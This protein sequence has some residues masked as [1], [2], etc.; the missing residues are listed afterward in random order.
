MVLSHMAAQLKQQLLADNIDDPISK[1][2]RRY[3]LW[4]ILAIAL[5][6]R[7]YHLDQ[8]LIDAF[9]WRQASTAMM[10]EN[11]YRTN[12][13]ILFPE[14]NWNGPGPSY[15]GREFQTLTYL[16]A[17]CYNLLGQQEWIG[18]AIAVGFGVWGVFALYQLVRCVWD[19]NRALAS[20]AVMAL[21]PGSV[22]ID[23]SFLPDPV[24]VALV[25]TGAWLLLRYLQ[26]N[27]LRDLAF[28]TVV[29]SW[30]FLS[31]LPGLII[32]LPMVWAM[33]LTLHHQRWPIRRIIAISLA[34][35][36]VLAPVVAYYLWARHLSLSYPPYHF[37]GSGTWVWDH[38]L[39]NW[40]RDAYYLPKLF[41]IVQGWL[42]TPPVIVLVGCGLVLP[43]PSR[44]ELAQGKP[45]TFPWFFHGWGLAVGLFYLI[46]AKEI[47]DNSWNLHL[48]NPAAAALA[49]H[50]I[51]SLTQL[52]LR[53]AP[54]WG[55][56]QTWKVAL[57]LPLVC[58]LAIGYYGRARLAYL[59][60]PYAMQS[61]QL[62]QNLEQVSQ[63]GDLVVTMANDLG[64]P[65]AIYYSH[66]R[67]WVFPPPW[68]DIAWGN[69][70]LEDDE[71]AIQWLD[72]LRGLDAR[73]FGVVGDR[74]DD[75][76]QNNP[77]F[78]AYLEQHSDPIK[79]TPDWVIYQLH[80]IS[81]S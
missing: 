79:K 13:N 65:I 58:Y 20:A 51:I 31:K 40:L 35:V 12:S 78:M 21:L 29:T 64:D 47:V 36:G 63:P 19:E 75:L 9:S 54:R 41:Q 5:V 1:Q 46:G 8:P 14:V 15:Q 6:L 25:T 69:P 26:T 73:W 34:S 77:G 67:G 18:R 38:G 66:R 42:W 50:G 3:G 56:V 45:P 10:A 11:F 80:S 17:L 55:T 37:A 22:F 32:G 70:T 24:M 68:D 23:R 52:A 60:Y 74:I 72:T 28:A 4:G 62:G 27:C 76:Y 2:W 49:G 30:A 53:Y 33:L 57:L 48:I 43:F 81:P 39:V 61:Y 59:Y 44:P 71:M 16:A 7:L